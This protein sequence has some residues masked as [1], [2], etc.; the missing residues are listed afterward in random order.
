MHG[1]DAQHR[2]SGPGGL[3]GQVQ[4]LAHPISEW[5]H[6]MRD[7]AREDIMTGSLFDETKKRPVYSSQLTA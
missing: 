6:R 3:P 2:Q 4:F 5:D 1:S 7:K